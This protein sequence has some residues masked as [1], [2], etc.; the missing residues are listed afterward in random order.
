MI[1]TSYY[2]NNLI[3]SL[4]PP[5]PTTGN[6]SHMDGGNMNGRWR[7]AGDGDGDDLPFNP[8]PGRVPE[9]ELLFPELR[10][11]VAAAL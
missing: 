10:F 3:Q 4:T 11:E 8:C 7:G 1:L 2:M 6:Y 9:Q 5:Q